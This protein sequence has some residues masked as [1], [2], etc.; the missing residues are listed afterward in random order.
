MR[1]SRSVFLASNSSDERMPA[2]RKSASLRI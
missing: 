2:S 1:E